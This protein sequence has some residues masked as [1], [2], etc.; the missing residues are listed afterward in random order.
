MVYAV[1][2]IDLEWMTGW[3]SVY[4]ATL[5]QLQQDDCEWWIE[6]D[7]VRTRNDRGSCEGTA[8]FQYGEGKDEIGEKGIV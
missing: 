4:V 2:Y 1:T 8:L 7:A 6:E 3:L 5:S